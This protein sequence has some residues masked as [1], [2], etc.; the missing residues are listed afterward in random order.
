MPQR[1]NPFT[2]IFLLLLGYLVYTAFTGPP[3]PTVSYTEFRELVRQGKVAEVTLEETRLQ[4]LLKEPERFPTPQGGSQVTR[5]FT[6]PLPPPA[7]ADRDLLP[8]LEAQGVRIVTKPPSLWP[9]VLLYVG[10]TLLLILFFFWFFMRAQGGAGQVM[11][12]G[13]SRA[14]LYGKEKQ[15]ST[16]FKD[17]AGHEEAK[18]EL[19]EV[20]DFLKDPKKYLDLGA[21]IPK[22]VL[23]VGPPGTGKTLLARAVAGEAGVPFFSVSASEFM[24]MFVGVGASRVRSLFEDARRNA[25]SIIF[26]DELDSIGRKRGAGIG[27]GHD[28]REQTLNQILSEMDGFEKD[29]SV[30]VLAATNR[31]DILDPALLRPGRFDR[32]V[33]VGLPS[34][35]ERKEILLVHMRKKPVDEGVDPLELAHLTPGFSGADLKNLVNEAALLAAREGAKRIRKDHF[36]KALDKIVLGLERPT[37]K[38]SEE[39]RRAVAYHEAG[40]AVVGEVLPHADKTE[41]VSIVP[42]GMALGARW[43]KPEERVLVSR[44]HLMDELSVLLAGRA[45]EE[46][47]TGTVTTGAQDDFKR[48][49]A[50]AKRMV[51]DWGMGAHFRNI[52]WGSDSGPVFLGE[53]IAKKK[54]HSEETARL[55]DQDIRAILDEAYERAQGVLREHQEAMHRIAEEL[56]REETIPGERVRA[57]LK[58]AEEAQ[59]V[60]RAAEE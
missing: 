59:P 30:I 3:A 19:M 33:V 29:T 51:L 18:R 2:L 56:L 27:G 15:V 57:I 48:A 7:V 50:L 60:Q 21:E 9:Q 38:L 39:E 49:T 41:K 6:V 5:R 42:R 46:L 24:E 58:E 13:Q 32:Q 20:V 22:G 35:E 43:S 25:P 14:K 11:Q 4:A 45:A 34:L 47:F 28:E 55:I 40:H 26:I 52:A 53:E 54:D 17:V 12:F 44:E 10:P 31:P 36:Q 8:F 23:L 1:I 16:T 37:L